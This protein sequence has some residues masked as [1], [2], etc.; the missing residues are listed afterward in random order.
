MRR[1]EDVGHA[2]VAVCVHGAGA[3]GWEW[4]SWKRMFGACG[5][6]AHAPDLQPAAGGLAATRFDDYRN[7]VIAHCR[8]ALSSGS[9][10]VIVGASLGGLLALSAAAEV[11]AAALVLINPMP[12]AGVISRSPGA[13]SA[14]IVPWGRERSIAGTRRAMPDADDA[15][16]LYAFRLWRDESGAVLD[17]A[18][19][20]I[21]VALPGCPTLVL[22]SEHDDDVPA[23]LSRA[24]AVRFGAD[25]ERL[26]ASSHLGPLLGTQSA[27]IAER[28]AT[29]LHMR[30]HAPA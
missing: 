14:A 7:Q 22:S 24:L 2:L 6:V 28:V 15:A 13:Q 29:W 1:D 18:R 25:F 3:G 20:G 19:A 12:P 10:L 17:Q 5:I 30:L 16:A 21:E 4:N 26:P 8:D 23:I 9:R 27:L 11:G